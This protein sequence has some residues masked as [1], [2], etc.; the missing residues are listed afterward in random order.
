MFMCKMT[1]IE[2][3]NKSGNLIIGVQLK[4]YRDHVVYIMC[5]Y[6]G[7]ERFSFDTFC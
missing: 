1:A 4:I 5:P 2:Y 6:N 3:H 7:Y